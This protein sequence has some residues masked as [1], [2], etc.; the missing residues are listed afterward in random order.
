MII[1]AHSKC[2]KCKKDIYNLEA[3]FCPHCGE[4]LLVKMGTSEKIKVGSTKGTAF[5]P[6]CGRPNEEE[7]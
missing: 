7:K 6:H 5:C 2:P 1:P 4:P 3:R